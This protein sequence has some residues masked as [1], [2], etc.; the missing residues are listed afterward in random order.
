M[1]NNNRL[2]LFHEKSMKL[3]L[4]G[5]LESAISFLGSIT[6]E[7]FKTKTDEVLIEEAYSK[8]AFEPITLVGDLTTLATIEVQKGTQSVIRINLGQAFSGTKDLLHA[9]YE[10]KANGT[11]PTYQQVSIW[12]F[13]TFTQ[14]ESQID[15]FVFQ[16]EFSTATE[17]DR[18]KAQVDMALQIIG[19]RIKDQADLIAQAEPEW[20]RK[21]AAKV[22]ERR[23]LLE[24]L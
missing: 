6:A 11:I 8:F 16:N 18:E 5:A 13:D 7:V 2:V 17:R 24:L 4:K 19:Y 10:V 1:S 23:R 3:L 21:L 9:D 22:T 15:R 20:R 14:N 12:Q